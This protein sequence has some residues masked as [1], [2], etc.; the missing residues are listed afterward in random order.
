LV[1]FAAYRFA[2]DGTGFVVL[3]SLSCGG[4]N[5]YHIIDPEHMEN[6]WHRLRSLWRAPLRQVN[7]EL[8]VY[9]PD[10]GGQEAQ[11]RAATEL[12]DALI[13]TPTPSHTVITD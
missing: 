9:L 1:P 10:F 13:A 7:E 12:L 11:T 8:L 6:R 2:Q 3:Q 4:E 5:G